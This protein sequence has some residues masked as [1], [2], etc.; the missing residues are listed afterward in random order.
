[1]DGCA[2]PGG[3]MSNI[4]ALLTA[5]NL[6]FPHVMLDGWNADDKPVGFAPASTHYSVTRG[7]MVSGMGMKQIREIPT[8]LKT[9]AM[10]TTSLDKA[11]QHEISI[12]NKPFFVNSLAGTTVMGGFDN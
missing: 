11:I 1:M 3:T 8:H 12:G 5:R 6:H 7:A 9:G 10:N 4:M 2:N